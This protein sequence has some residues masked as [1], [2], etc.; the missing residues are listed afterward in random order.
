M[1]FTVGSHVAPRHDVEI[2]YQR[3]HMLAH[4]IN[5]LI[6]DYQ[7]CHLSTPIALN[8]N[9]KGVIY[10]LPVMHTT[11]HWSCP[12]KN[13]KKRVREEAKRQTLVPLGRLLSGQVLQKGAFSSCL[14]GA[15]LRV[16][17]FSRSPFPSVTFA[18]TGVCLHGTEAKCNKARAIMGAHHGDGI[19]IQVSCA[20][21]LLLLSLRKQWS[22]L[23]AANRWGLIP[24]AFFSPLPVL[25]MVEG[26]VFHP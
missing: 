23:C 6:R 19:K 21:L 22:S 25:V 11:A 8:K 20:I 10:F 2:L 26:V 24:V 14:I 1:T 12:F 13:K 4:V 18:R 16:L 17:L 7:K 5:L 15:L 3:I 9:V